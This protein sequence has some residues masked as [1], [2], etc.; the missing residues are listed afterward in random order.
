MTQT[1][2]KISPWKRPSVNQPMEHVFWPLKDPREERCPV[3][4]N[5]VKTKLNKRRQHFYREWYTDSTDDVPCRHTDEL[6]A[7]T[8]QWLPMQ[9]VRLALVSLRHPKP[10]MHPFFWLPLVSELA[11]LGGL[12]C[13]KFRCKSQISSPFL[14]LGPPFWGQKNVKV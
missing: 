8:Q 6:G 11:P 3:G 5:V 13:S 14:G 10:G 4:M 2:G 9:G 12:W 1:A 7:L